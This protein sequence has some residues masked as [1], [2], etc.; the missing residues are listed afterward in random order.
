M[1]CWLLCKNK[2]CHFSQFL[3]AI[4]LFHLVMNFKPEWT[5]HLSNQESKVNSKKREL[6]A[7]SHP[8]IIKYWCF[9]LSSSGSISSPGNETQHLIVGNQPEHQQLIFHQLNCLSP[10]SLT[11]QLRN[12]VHCLCHTKSRD[13][14]ILS[15]K[16]QKNNNCELL[17]SRTGLD[18]L[19]RLSGCTFRY[20][21]SCPLPLCITKWIKECKQSWRGM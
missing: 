21:I 3:F 7:A 1:S 5:L 4:F 18:C 17:F 11:A 16:K 9:R 15:K 19:K 6:I 8:Q 13:F 14:A 10:E 20:I 2:R 12:H